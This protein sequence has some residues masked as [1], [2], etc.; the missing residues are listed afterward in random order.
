MGGYFL[1]SFLLLSLLSYDSYLM[2]IGSP[3]CDSAWFFMCGKAWMEGMTPYVDFAD[4]KGIL[5]WLF[6]GIGYL[7]SPTS[8]IGVFWL[9]VIA[10]AVTFNFIWKTARL[11][12][13]RRQ[14]LLV[15]AVMPFFLFL[16]QFHNEVRAEDFC[17]PAVCAG[18]YFSVL[19]LRDPSRSVIRR[20]AFCLGI[21]M[22]WCLLI[23]WS[24]FF[25]MGGMALI[26]V[27][28]SFS[29]KSAAGL[30]FGLLGMAVMA[31]PFLV[32][33][34]IEGNFGAFVQEY[35][36]NTFNIAGN[37]QFIQQLNG[38]SEIARL[39]ALCVFPLLCLFPFVSILFILKKCPTDN[40][41]LA[42][43]CSFLAV[44]MPI[45][46]FFFG[47]KVLMHFIRLY[48]FELACKF[49]YGYL[50]LGTIFIG[51]TLFCRRFKVSYW[52]LLAFIP[53]FM[54]LGL[55]AVFPYYFSIASPFYIFIVMYMISICCNA[56]KKINIGTHISNCCYC[57]SVR[58]GL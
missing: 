36:I 10:Y 31:L 29:K 12:L 53:I 1:L 33:F 16:C 50:G 58:C 47:E 57:C 25:M 22:V 44:A 4:S 9:S 51:I 52:L 20:C 13:D 46:M 56:K 48:I 54:F 6:Y 55:K 45:C 14:S 23:K 34:V 28:V 7:L 42:I 15:L 35:F 5:L 43:F 40:L 26:V 30:I 21:A 49:A 19:V 3:R 8:Y 17:Y 27:G 18:I 2:H 39:C 11:F 41:R 38:I 32:Y 37:P 24:I